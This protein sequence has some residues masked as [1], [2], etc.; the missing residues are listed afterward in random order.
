MRWVINTIDSL[1]QPT[2]HTVPK[3]NIRKVLYPKILIMYK[4]L[5]LSN[6]IQSL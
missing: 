1:P 6:L 4:N 3:G 2:P 5:S